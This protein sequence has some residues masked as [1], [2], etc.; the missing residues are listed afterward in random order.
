MFVQHGFVVE[1]YCYVRNIVLGF[2][3]YIPLDFSNCENILYI[4]CEIDL[5]AGNCDPAG[6]K[7]TL[8]RIFILVLLFNAPSLFAILLP[9][10]EVP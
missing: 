7:S 5:P 9:G 4:W 10:T 3:Q 8:A 2:L 1:H 6:M